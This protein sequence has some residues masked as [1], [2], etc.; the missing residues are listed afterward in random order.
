MGWSTCYVVI[1]DRAGRQFV[2][3]VFSTVVLFFLFHVKGSYLSCVN[4]W[5]NLRQ[6]SVQMQVFNQLLLNY[7]FHWKEGDLVVIFMDVIKEV[8][9]DLY[10]RFFIT[11]W[12][13]CFT[14]FFRNC[15]WCCH[16]HGEGNSKCNEYIQSKKQGQLAFL[17]DFLLYFHKTCR[18][19]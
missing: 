15:N 4:F 9:N 13:L 16:L 19:T 8:I 17:C 18:C 12:H 6:L 2:Y 1:G 14:L 3:D 10:N 5:K 7:C 11:T